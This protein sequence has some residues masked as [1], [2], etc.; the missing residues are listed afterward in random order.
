MP[1]INCISVPICSAERTACITKAQQ[2]IAIFVEDAGRMDLWAWAVH[3]QFTTAERDLYNANVKMCLGKC[4]NGP[5][6][7]LF[8]CAGLHIKCARVYIVRQP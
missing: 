6:I 3:Q 5:V 2:T 8:S 1:H 4:G 7:H